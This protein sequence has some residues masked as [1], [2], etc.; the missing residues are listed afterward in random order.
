[1]EEHERAPVVALD[2]IGLSRDASVRGCL[3]VVAMGDLDSTNAGHCRRMAGGD[4]E[5]CPRV[6]RAIAAKQRGHE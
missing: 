5:R 4:Y 3:S 1:M 6:L 2:A